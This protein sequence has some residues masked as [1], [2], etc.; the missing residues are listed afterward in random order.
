MAEALTTATSGA[1][2]ACGVDASKGRLAPGQ[3]ADLLV[4]NGELHTDI[5]ALLRP[6]ALLLHGD[7]VTI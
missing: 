1:A 6:Q 4:V 3:H 2:I 5:T 7:P